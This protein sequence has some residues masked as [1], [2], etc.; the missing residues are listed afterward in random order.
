MYLLLN[1]LLSIVL[2]LIYVTISKMIL[3]GS[4]PP[5]FYADSTRVIM[6]VS[7]KLKSWR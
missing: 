4:R 6:T 7:P 3:I 5:P 2:G 1:G